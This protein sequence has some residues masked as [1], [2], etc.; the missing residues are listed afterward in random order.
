MRSKEGSL[1]ESALIHRA[2]AGAD[3]TR[4]ADAVVSVWEEIDAAL[5][6][7]LGE[8]GVAALYERS[9]CRSGILTPDLATASE[10][11]RLPM[12]MAALKVL[13]ACQDAA[14]AVSKG[15][16]LLQTFYDLLVT[17]VGPLLTERLL[18]SVWTK[19]SGNPSQ[20]DTSS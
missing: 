3:A 17:L 9:L 16:A 19:F 4:V 20:Q 2:G 12:D 8:G 11:S 6:P 7:I 13:L 18:R 10:Q 5:R 15:V 14:R 1:I